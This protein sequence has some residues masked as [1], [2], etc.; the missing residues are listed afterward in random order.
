MLKA[1]V[2]ENTAY[3]EF[4]I[5]RDQMASEYRFRMHYK[6]FVPNLLLWL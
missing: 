5:M 3:E 6:A 1:Q 2:L 4:K